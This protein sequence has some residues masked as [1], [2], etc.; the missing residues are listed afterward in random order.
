MLLQQVVIYLNQTP[1]SFRYEV[2][3]NAHEKFPNI[4]A[5][6]D[7]TIAKNADVKV[8]NLKGDRDNIKITYKEDLKIGKMIINKQNK[9]NI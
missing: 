1:Q 7:I 8:Y 9:E 6:D 5:T 4:N 2:I 3:L